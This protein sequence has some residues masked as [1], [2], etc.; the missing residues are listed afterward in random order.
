MK[1]QESLIV[2]L[3]QSRHLGEEGVV[4]ALSSLGSPCCVQ[5]LE[6]LVIECCKQH[7]SDA[8]RTCLSISGIMLSD[9][10]LDRCIRIC[11]AQHQPDTATIVVASLCS[12]RR[13]L[14]SALEALLVWVCRQKYD[15]RNRRFASL[16]NM[17][18]EQ[19]VVDVA[20]SNNLALRT[21]CQSGNR[22]VVQRLLQDAR[23]D[24]TAAQNHALRCACVHNH[25]AVVADLLDDHRV[26]PSSMNQAA[27]QDA[28]SHRSHA[29]VSVLLKDHRVD[30]SV[31]GPACV[32]TMIAREDYDRCILQVLLND[33]RVEISNHHLRCI[34]EHLLG[35]SGL[36]GLSNLSDSTTTT[37][38]AL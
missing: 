2:S 7:H 18:I 29:T 10:T 3:Y 21:A 11:I 28:L 38:H 1:G 27:L 5:F 17:L 9:A 15:T 31:C 24:P 20:A 13:E 4:H 6:Q 33:K 25:A 23:V 16:L 32:E 8:L 14:D 26:D 37:A 12:Y 34:I 19:N 36:N 22:E 35:A 30:P